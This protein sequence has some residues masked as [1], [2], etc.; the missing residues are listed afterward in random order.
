METIT[1]VRHIRQ[2]IVEPLTDQ[3]QNLGIPVEQAT[4][5]HAHPNKAFLD[6][7]TAEEFD[8][9]LSAVQSVAVPLH[10]EDW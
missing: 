3:D 4:G 10:Q 2:N 1:T 7:L 6:T 8:R 9:I 5:N